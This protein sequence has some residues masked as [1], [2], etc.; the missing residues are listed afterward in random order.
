MVLKSTDKGVVLSTK[1]NDIQPKKWFEFRYF[2]ID[3]GFD[4]ANLVN[5][6]HIGFRI[7]LSPTAGAANWSGVLYADHFQ[8][9][10]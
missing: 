7:T 2:P 8:L 3:D 6:T 10:K 4:K 5:I 1:T 9:R